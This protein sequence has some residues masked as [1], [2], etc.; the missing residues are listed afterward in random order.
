V[1]DALLFPTLRRVLV[2]ARILAWFMT[3]DVDVDFDFNAARLIESDCFLRAN[4]PIVL[5]HRIRP[6]TGEGRTAGPTPF[7]F[8]PGG[9]LNG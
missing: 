7:S 3:Q 6:L 2:R 8:R 5:S 1:F 9:S 4:F